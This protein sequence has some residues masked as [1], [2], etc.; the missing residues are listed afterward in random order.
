[1][2]GM[3]TY[4]GAMGDICVGGSGVKAVWWC[5]PPSVAMDAGQACAACMLYCS[6]PGFF[7]QQ[8]RW[9]VWWLVHVQ[10]MSML[11]HT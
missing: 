9:G 7:H 3:A 5:G 8:A 2:G 10:V 6:G 4:E 1:M 11:S